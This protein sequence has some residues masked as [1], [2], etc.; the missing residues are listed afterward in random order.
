MNFVRKELPFFTT[1][2]PLSRCIQNLYDK[3][4]HILRGFAFLHELIPKCHHAVNQQ[5]VFKVRQLKLSIL[6]SHRFHPLSCIWDT[7]LCL[8][9]LISFNFI[10]SFL[11]YFIVFGVDSQLNTNSVCI[12][13]GIADRV[14][15]NNIVFQSEEIPIFFT[16]TFLRTYTSLHS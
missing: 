14:L 6:L 1:E 2:A 12:P 11:L 4:V 7:V 3:I 8:R 5:T 16:H 9:A 13:L 10:N 15:T